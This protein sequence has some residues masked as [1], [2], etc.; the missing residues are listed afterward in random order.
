VYHMSLVCADPYM[1]TVLNRE[2]AAFENKTA[3]RSVADTTH[4]A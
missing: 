3:P 1:S 4:R 2:K